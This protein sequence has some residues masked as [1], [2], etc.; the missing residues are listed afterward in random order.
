MVIIMYAAYVLSVQILGV[1]TCQSGCVLEQL[2]N[3]VGEQG[4][5]MPLDLGAKGTCQIGGN[6]STNA[7][8][9]LIAQLPDVSACQVLPAMQISKCQQFCHMHFCGSVFTS[10]TS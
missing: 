1:L 3:V 6:V 8:D 9:Q 10:A 7:G 2:D 5:T 4:H